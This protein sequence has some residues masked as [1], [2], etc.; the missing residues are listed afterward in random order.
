MNDLNQPSWLKS[1]G[2]LH[3]TAQID[4]NKRAKELVSKI[5]N[6]DFVSKYAFFPL[7]H[8]NISERK[9]KKIGIDSTLRAHSYKNENGEFKKNKKVR[10]LHYATHL[11]ALI[12]GYYAEV[13]QK[14]YEELIS[15][16][17]GLG[18]CIIAYRKIF[19]ELDG[20]N[21]GTIHFA[22][23]IF[24]EIKKQ[25]NCGDEECVVLTFDIKSFFSSLDHE[26]LK[27]AW[28]KLIDVSLL[29][30][31]HYNVFKAATQF[32]YI[33]LDDLRIKS[34]NESKKNGFDERDLARI[35]NKYGVQA[36]FA[37]PKEFR[38]QVKNGSLKLYKYPFRDIKSKI[39]IGI[40]Q[41]LP[42]SA[43]LANLYLL[44]FDLH[45][46]NT[47]VNKL[48]G[49]YRRYSDD[50]VIVCSKSNSTLIEG[51]IHSKIKEN[52]VEISVN[53]TERF[54]LKNIAFGKNTPRLTCLKMLENGKE[55]CIPFNYLGFEF[56][57]QKSLIKSTNIAKFY[58]RMISS[59]KSKAKKAKLIAEKNPGSKPVIFRRQLYKLY[60]TRP[61]NNVKVRNRW[62]KIVKMDNGNFRL[63]TIKKQKILRSNYLSYVQRACEIME[64]PHIAKQ[65]RKHKKVFNDSINRHLK[66]K[67]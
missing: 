30:D 6:P 12:F 26:L 46:F 44:S 49:Y 27:K 50:I 43:I 29:P 45:I 7:I 31:D 25:S 21:K 19:N 16:C 34:K 53:K 35:R 48:G 63:V 58:R 54:I 42:I 28:A 61:L 47:V 37:N 10:P 23:E 55:V 62:K 11:D 60:T 17:E 67:D 24:D 33:F 38:D 59:V 5:T 52:R 9:F 36:L 56:D 22:K 4:V 39:P 64:E 65:I 32:S 20:K 51:I 3:V 1:K 66:N 15:R 8:T 41:G 2:Y 14:K 40:P 18:N 13:L 57:G